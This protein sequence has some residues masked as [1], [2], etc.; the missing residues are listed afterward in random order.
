MEYVSVDLLP[1]YLDVVQ[2]AEGA[3]ESY[4]NAG[5]EDQDSA[6]LLGE[7]A[8]AVPHDTTGG[9][10]D[11]HSLYEREFFLGVGFMLLFCFFGGVELML[12]CASDFSK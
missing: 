6:N 5:V 4:R 2:P 1:V 12:V 3:E 11:T 8:C 7:G 10:L 9:D